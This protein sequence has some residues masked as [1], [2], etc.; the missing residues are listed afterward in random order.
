MTAVR[1][2]KVRAGY[3]GRPALH[4]VSAELRGGGWLAVVG[5]NGAGKSTLL[6]V[7]A[8]LLPFHGEVALDGKRAERLSRKEKARLIGYAP[9]NPVLPGGLRVTDYVL[10]GRTPHLGPLAREGRVDLSIVDDVL[11]R[12][13]LADLAG[14]KLHTLSGGERR[15]AVLAR[16]LAQR[17][18]ILLLD[19]PTAGLDLGHAQELLE[20][21]DRLRSEDGTTVVSTVHDLTLAAQYAGRLLLLAGGE[22]AA[23]GAPAEVLTPDLL[24]RHYGAAAD[25]L[26]APRG[27]LVIAPIRR[28]QAPAKGA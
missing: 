4:G 25:V 13:D 8:G 28:G 18:R 3:G 9:Q 6:K 12:L 26:V 20:L 27:E 23:D 16:V 15:R 2:V 21:L 5:P 17:A 7:L 1:A 19:E 24:A 10:L 14:R 11:A 22:V